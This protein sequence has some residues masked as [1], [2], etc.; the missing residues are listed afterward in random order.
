MEQKSRGDKRC[1]VFLQENNFFEWDFFKKT[2]FE[3]WKTQEGD[4][5]NIFLQML[6]RRIFSKHEKISRQWDLDNHFVVK[7]IFVWNF[8]RNWKKVFFWKRELRKKSK[9]KKTI[10]F[11][12]FKK[13]NRNS[14]NKFLE[15]LHKWFFCQKKKVNLS[16]SKEHAWKKGGAKLLAEHLFSA[17]SSACVLACPFVHLFCLSVVWQVLT[18]GYVTQPFGLAQ[19]RVKR[20]ESPSVICTSSCCMF[21]AARV[22]HWCIQRFLSIPFSTWTHVVFRSCARAR[23]TDGGRGY[24]SGHDKTRRGSMFHLQ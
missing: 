9:K 6:E 19:V 24:C 7:S 13:K 23:Y 20:K 8:L 22:L 12:F 3:R 17:L 14:E 21:W 10:N 16:C 11:F 18:Q 15:V 4:D 2:F 5:K 1:F